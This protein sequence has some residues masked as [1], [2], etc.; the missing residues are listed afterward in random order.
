MEFL[1]ER[2]A[3]LAPGLHSLAIARRWACLR[4]FAPDR[5]PFI[6]WD[7][8]VQPLFWVAGLGGHG[9]TASAAIG[10]LAAETILERLVPRRFDP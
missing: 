8:T 2:T 10:A 9:A 7:R 3:A 1:A 5:R 6:G 4:T